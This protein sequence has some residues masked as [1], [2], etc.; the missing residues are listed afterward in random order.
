MRYSNLRPPVG[1]VNFA[2]LTLNPL[3]LPPFGQ[4]IKT[5]SGEATTLIF[6]MIHPV[7]FSSDTLTWTKA[8]GSL[9]PFFCSFVPIYSCP[10]TESS[11]AQKPQQLISHIAVQGHPQ[12]L[13]SCFYPLVSLGAEG[14]G[15]PLQKAL[16]EPWA[17]SQ[18]PRMKFVLFST[19]SVAVNMCELQFC[20]QLGRS[21]NIIH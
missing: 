9:L 19:W 21:R 4:G 18:K 16:I 1:E 10:S 15:K 3:S 14:G 7:H 5:R 17:C 13:N 2:V 20:R 11:A 6:W 8:R 12:E